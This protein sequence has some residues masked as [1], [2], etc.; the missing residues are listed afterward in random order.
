MAIVGGGEPESAAAAEPAVTTRI[1][2]EG[3][4]SKPPRRRNGWR[5]SRHRWPDWS[6]ALRQELTRLES[7][8]QRAEAHAGAPDRTVTLDKIRSSLA[9]VRAELQR[10]HDA[11]AWR[12]LNG[13]SAYERSWSRI[14][15]AAEDLLLVLPDDDVRAQVPGL[16][17]GLKTYLGAD[18]VRHDAFSRLLDEVARTATV[19]GDD[20]PALDRRRLSPDEGNI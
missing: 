16:R 13:A 20:D 8:V 11:A 10:I 9:D 12:G 3:V 6:I 4:T 14:F 19:T 17:A 1:P 7:D 15:L 5:L 18:D 2:E